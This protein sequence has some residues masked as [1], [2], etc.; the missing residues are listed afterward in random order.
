[1]P[2]LVRALPKFPAKSLFASMSNK[3]V[4][5]RQDNLDAYLRELVC[6]SEGTWCYAGRSL[7]GW[8]GC[9]VGGCVDV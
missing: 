5:L 8:C 9:C 1:M 2:Q 4:Q 7:A 6:H 3:T